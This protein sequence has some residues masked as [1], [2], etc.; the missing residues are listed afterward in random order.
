MMD[1]PNFDPDDHNMT[2]V[3]QAE[4]EEG[5]TFFPS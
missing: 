5:L 4:M 2:A 1:C 3:I